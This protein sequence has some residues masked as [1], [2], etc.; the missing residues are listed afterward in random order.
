MVYELAKKLSSGLAVVSV[1]DQ[2]S[3]FTLIVPVAAGE[4]REKDE[5]GWI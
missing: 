1:L 2:G 4:Q 5:P 3:T